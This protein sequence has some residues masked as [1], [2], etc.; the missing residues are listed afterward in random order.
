VVEMVRLSGATSTSSAKPLAVLTRDNRACLQSLNNTSGFFG[1]GQRRTH[2]SEPSLTDPS[3]QR[4]D[5][6]SIASTSMIDGTCSF[7][8]QNRRQNDRSVARTWNCLLST[9]VVC[10][11]CLKQRQG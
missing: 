4:A 2:R 6:Q 10:K 5:F 1:R 3:S 9:A 11:S 8:A 7:S